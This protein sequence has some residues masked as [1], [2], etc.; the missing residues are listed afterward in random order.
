MHNASNHSLQEQFGVPVN[1]HVKAMV[2]QGNYEG[3]RRFFD[4]INRNF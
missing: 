4:V 1:S 2:L 3:V